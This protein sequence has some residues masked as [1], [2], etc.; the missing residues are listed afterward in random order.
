MNRFVR[1]ICLFLVIWHGPG[2]DVLGEPKPPPNP[3][4]I[5]TE[6]GKT[7]EKPPNVLVALD[8]EISNGNITYSVDVQMFSIPFDK[9]A[10]VIETLED[11]VKSD[12]KEYTKE[13]AGFS[14]RKRVPDG[15][16]WISLSPI[17]AV[18][19]TRLRLNVEDARSLVDLFKQAS[20]IQLWLDERL[21]SYKAKK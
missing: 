8:A 17:D 5:R 16:A 20:D 21:V 18:V 19:Y 9:I 11:C 4:R 14:F 12:D 6:V 15:Q 1:R 2:A 13:K 7:S 3:I 10:T